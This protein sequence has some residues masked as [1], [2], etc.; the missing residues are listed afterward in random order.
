M[1]TIN[2]IHRNSSQQV[3]WLSLCFRELTRQTRQFK[4]SST[5]WMTA[6]YYLQSLSGSTT[7]CRSV[8]TTVG[9]FLF[10]MNF[11]MYCTSCEMF[12]SITFRNLSLSL[13]F[14]RPP[15]LPLSLS[16]SLPPTLPSST[17]HRYVHSLPPFLPPSLPP[18]LLPSLS[19]SLPP[20]LPPFTLHRYVHSLPPFL[21]PSLLSHYTGMCMCTHAHTTHTQHTT[22]QGF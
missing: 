9:G 6:S 10:T 18:S 14:T 1:N 22:Y 11:I 13:L 4:R 19:P 20:S 17:L 12:S 16:P 5:L 15:S 7:L 8:C 2:T 3:N 21:P